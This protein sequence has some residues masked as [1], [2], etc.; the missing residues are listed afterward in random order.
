MLLQGSDSTREAIIL[1]QFGLVEKSV[2]LGTSSAQKIAG[3]LITDARIEQPGF[4]ILDARDYDQLCV[5]YRKVVAA[6]QQ[7]LVLSGGQSPT[8]L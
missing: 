2:K 7:Q 3:A 5:F 4:T 6:D 8:G 1:N